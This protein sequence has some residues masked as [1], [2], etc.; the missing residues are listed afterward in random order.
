MVDKDSTPELLVLNRTVTLKEATGK[1]T[2]PK[3]KSRKEQQ[4]RQN[5]IERGTAV[6]E[7]RGGEICL[8]FS[9][10]MFVAPKPQLF[11]PPDRC[12]PMLC[13]L[14]K[15]GVDVDVRSPV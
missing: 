15:T 2:V 10:G 1:S 12:P 6:R 13:K 9:C 14:N 5:R 7:R 11:S 4:V 3:D 8:A